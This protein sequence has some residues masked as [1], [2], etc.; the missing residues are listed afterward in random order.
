MDKKKKRIYVSVPRDNNL[1]DRQRALKHA[2]K[3]KLRSN[4]LEPQEFHVEG[5]PLRTAYTF[6]AV[7]DIMA[8]CHGA[9][10]LAFA[11]WQD[12]SG[13]KRLT[14]PTVWNH[15]EG[16]FAVALKKEILVVT[17]EHVSEDGI[18]WGGGGQII[19]RAPSDAGPEWLE[20][21]YAKHQ[22]GAWID[23]VKR[24]R[25]VF[26]AYSSK[27]RATA[28][29]LSKFLAS[30]G[31]S[32]LDWEIDFTPGGVILD[33]LMVAARSCL[34]AIMLLT[35][36][37]EFFGAETYAAPR[38]NVI[39]EMGMFMESKGRERVL[40]VREEGAKMPADIGGG[41]YLSLK[42]RNDIAPIHGKLLN[43]IE[44]RL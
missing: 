42:D 28:N 5:L 31:V 24:V 32:V 9:L 44:K 43:F 35:K 2:I 6:D 17:E 10:V 40:V 1:D 4:E 19:V 26:L 7:G 18:T 3:K 16:A 20:D 23:A 39:F 11:R 12:P 14:M 13:D 15:F 8:R 22:F 41:I 29:D 37:D 38:D 36:D 34:G 27:A 33:E 25:D 21:S 30:R